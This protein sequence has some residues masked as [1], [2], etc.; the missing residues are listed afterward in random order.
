MATE[1]YGICEH[2]RA[3]LQELIQQHDVVWVHTIRTAQWFQIYRWPHSVLD[4][5]DLPSRPYQLPERSGGSLVRRMLDLRMLWIWRRRERMLSDRFDV[6]A[7]CS[8]EDRRYLG[9]SERLHV[10]PNGAHPLKARPRTYSEMQ[11]IGLI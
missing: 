8:E 9:I 7:V 2:D 3:A 6:L 4:V 5:D 1:P 11:R 10:I